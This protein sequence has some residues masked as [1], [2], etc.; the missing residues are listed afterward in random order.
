[1]GSRR[2]RT[3]PDRG[4]R[5]DTGGG[6]TTRQPPQASPATGR[7]VL[8]PAGHA[9]SSFFTIDQGKRGTLLRKMAL[10]VAALSLLVAMTASTAFAAS[11][12]ATFAQ[13]CTAN[14]GQLNTGS[15]KT[16]RDDSCRVT[17]TF[18]TTNSGGSS[19][20]GRAGLR[21]TPM[22]V[23]APPTN[24]SPLAKARSLRAAVRPRACP[25]VCRSRPWIRAGVPNRGPGPFARPDRPR[26]PG[27]P[28]D[29]F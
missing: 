17:S 7:R 12:S 23:R 15:K 9:V 2:P 3:V 20:H 27:S 18:N 25:T 16:W 22:G 1:V 10:L 19:E 11:P 26:L 29:L 6:S 5:I 4:C 8:A 21:R 28:I 13:G 24:S 14:G